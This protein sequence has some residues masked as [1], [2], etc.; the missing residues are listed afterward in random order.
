MSGPEENNGIRRGW[1][2][3]GARADTQREA[4]GHFKHEEDLKCFV[5]E[6]LL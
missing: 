4:T 1:R 6:N 2:E 3:A 5:F